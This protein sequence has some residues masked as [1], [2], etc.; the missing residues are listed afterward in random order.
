MAK[1]QKIRLKNIRS[2][3]EETEIDLTDNQS[4]IT[5]IGGRNGRG[6]ST[7]FTIGI[8]MLLGF[9]PAKVH[10]SRG[11]SEGYFILTNEYGDFSVHIKE[12]GNPT[13]G[14][15]LKT[16][17]SDYS[18]DSLN[19]NRCLSV[20]RTYIGFDFDEET[21]TVLNINEKDSLNF[22][23]TNGR[24]DLAFLRSLLYSEEVEDLQEDTKDTIKSSKEMINK[25]SYEIDLLTRD[26]IGI[27]T[28][29][30]EFID[31]LI[32]YGEYLMKFQNAYDRLKSNIVEISLLY[33]KT[34]KNSIDKMT[35]EIDKIQMLS[36]SLVVVSKILQLEGRRQNIDSLHNN[37]D[38]IIRN[39]KKL[40]TMNEL[41]TKLQK[42]ITVSKLKENI[43]DYLVMSREYRSKSI[44]YNNQLVEQFRSRL[45]DV[46]SNLYSSKKVST[47][48]P[49]SNFSLLFTQMEGYYKLKE[50]QIKV[51]EELDSMIYKEGRCILCYSKKSE[52]KNH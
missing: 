38:N 16:G 50:R 17:E 46:L 26:L 34:N 28:K 48:I 2:I 25:V 18:N 6:K 47:V 21:K 1:I 52:C 4:G 12:K 51:E 35:L 22:I 39:M 42:F 15:K 30:P 33:M 29:S 37:I 43:S 5:R 45:E 9:T 7:I 32:E 11:Y 13:Y 41:E 49:F 44:C 20:I 3:T 40:Y 24:S 27:K 14:Y 23:V 31:E 8:R 10:L 36:A 19:H